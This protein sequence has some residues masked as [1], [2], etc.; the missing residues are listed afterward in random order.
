MGFATND[1]TGNTVIVRHFLFLGQNNVITQ[2]CY[3]ISN[4]SEAY[5]NFKQGGDD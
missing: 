2:L 3:Q 4:K 5:M 1:N